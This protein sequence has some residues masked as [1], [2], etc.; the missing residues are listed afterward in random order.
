M[1]VSAWVEGRG[2]DNCLYRWRYTVDPSIR[3]GKVMLPL[4]LTHRTA[5]DANS[6]ASTPSP[7][8]GVPPPELQWS[9]E[10]DELLTQGV[11]R[12][13][14]GANDWSKWVDGPSGVLA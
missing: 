10:E 9:E 8:G 13:P 12:N 2:P 5:T 14:A 4:L 7:H 3:R 1:R 6:R 11:A